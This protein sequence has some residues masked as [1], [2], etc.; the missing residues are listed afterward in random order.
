MASSGSLGTESSTELTVVSM[1]A[2]G[3]R[4]DPP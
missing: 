2:V 3:Q 1:E 4:G